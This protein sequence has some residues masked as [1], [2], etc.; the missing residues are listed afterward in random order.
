MRDTGSSC[1][2]LVVQC[3]AGYS[4]S[5]VAVLQWSGLLASQMVGV[6]ENQSDD[7]NDDRLHKL[8]DI[9]CG[10]RYHMESLTIINCI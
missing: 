4:V 2:G 6:D 1:P 8:S 10:R 3:S 7:R 9:W 5:S